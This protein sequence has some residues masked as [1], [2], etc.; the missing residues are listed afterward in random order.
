MTDAP[1]CLCCGQNRNKAI[2]AAG[3]ISLRRCLVCDLVFSDP[4]AAVDPSYYQEHIV[5]AR[6]TIREARAE[7]MHLD[8]RRLAW[9]TALTQPRA[10]LLDIGCG[11][12]AFVAHARNAGRDA[13]GIDFNDQEISVG[14][15]AFQLDGFLMTGDVL[16][17]PDS[18]SEFD[19]ITMFEVIEHLPNP[20][21]VIQEAFRRLKKGG[22]LAI[23]CPN[24]KRWQP[25][26]RIFVDYPPH[27]LTRWT[28]RGLQHFL[29]ANSFEH[30]HTEVDASFRDII[31]TAYVNRRARS[32]SMD[33]HPGIAA[34]PD[35]DQK[36]GSSN[37]KWK[38]DRVL[39]I[40]CA[41][42]DA[43][44]RALHVGTMGM[45]LIVRKP[46]HNNQNDP[47]VRL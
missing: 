15:S 11:S 6:K 28:P 3:V 25:A 35:V 19:L 26:G 10:K 20:R 27:H 38:L 46:T 30:V 23:S 4:M 42:F 13:Y 32:K 12:G 1:A 47:V 31:W 14:R 5:Y 17:M 7:Q 8:P 34:L 33:P 22:H 2:Y 39:R 40:C 44:L 18:W 16:A 45:R 41:P 9:M 43:I 37:W 36:T 24:E 21:Q 29:E